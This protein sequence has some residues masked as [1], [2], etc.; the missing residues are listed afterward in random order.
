MMLRDLDEALRKQFG[1]FVAVRRGDL[2]RAEEQNFG[3]LGP[4]GAG[5][6]TLIRMLTTLM[7]PTSGAAIGVGPQP[8]ERARFGAAGH[9]VIPQALTSDPDLTAEENLDFLARLY[10][11]PKAARGRR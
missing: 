8:P 9:G 1:D 6:S 3:L 4:N 7:Q 2:R 5:K 11:V 10:S